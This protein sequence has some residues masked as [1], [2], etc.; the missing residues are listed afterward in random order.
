MEGRVALGKH[1]IAEIWVKDRR[2]LNDLDSLR[3]SLLSAADRGGFSVVDVLMHKFSPHGITGVV[4][5]S[6]SHM[7]IHTWPEHLYAAVDIFTCG[8]APWA[9]LEELERRLDVEHMEVR[10]LER[11]LV[12]QA[13]PREAHPVGG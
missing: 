13:E 5:L 10:E 12:G 2:R 6:E 8:G 9:A 1:V 11:G 4:L 3:E 7:S